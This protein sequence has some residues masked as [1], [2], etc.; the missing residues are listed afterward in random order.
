MS[1]GE[2]R[3]P[4]VIGTDVFS[5]DLVLRSRLTEL[6]APIVTGRLFKRSP[7]CDMACCSLRG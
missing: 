7:S 4:I 2:P 6:Y 3:G 5:A 1:P